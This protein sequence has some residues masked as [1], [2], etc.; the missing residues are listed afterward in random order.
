MSRPLR[1]EYPGAWYHVMNR[2]L[3]KRN[4][5]RSDLDRRSFLFLLGETVRC[6]G[7]EVH[8]FSLMPNHYHLLVHTPQ[9]GLS[10]AMRH[11]NGVYTQKANWHWKSDGPIFRGRYKAMLVEKEEY[12]LELVRYIHMNP[13]QAG[14]CDVPEDHGW[15][16]HRMYLKRDQKP[17]WLATDEV[18]SYFG[19]R[20]GESISEMHRYV[21]EGIPVPFI[22]VLDQQQAILGTKGFCEW[23]YRNFGKKERDK[24]GIPLKVR[25]PRRKISPSLILK[26]VAHAYHVPIGAV[27]RGCSG[28]EN[29]ARSTAIYLG[30]QLANI[31]HQEL[32]RWIRASDGNAVGQAYYRFKQKL[33]RDQKAKQL[34]VAIANAILNNVKP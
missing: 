11:L 13:V 4:I 23:V 34:T 15:T 33:Q 32:S 12:L 30:R 14:L 21:C 1:I 10:R 8:A 31:S 2:G 9:A 5:F 17:D 27:R 7:I 28:V 19:G 29:E 24:L 22:N 20:K 26:K 3:A 6:Y 25:K 16:S 18:L